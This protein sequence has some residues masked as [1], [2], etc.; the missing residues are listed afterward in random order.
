VLSVTEENAMYLNN[1]IT[2]RI[3]ATFLVGALAL[4][5]AACNSDPEDQVDQTENQVEDQVDEKE[6]EVRENTP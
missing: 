6:K 2:R 4:G 5:S 1:S 3:G